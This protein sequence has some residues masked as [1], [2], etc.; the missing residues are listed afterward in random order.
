VAVAAVVTAGAASAQSHRS[1]NR[2]EIIE[3][4]EPILISRKVLRLEMQRNSDLRDW[5]RLYGAPDYA[6]VQEI[7]IDPPFAPYEVRLYYLKGN[8][9]LVFGRVHVA[10]SLYDYGV[11][12]YYGHITAADMDRLLTA[13]PVTYGEVGVTQTTAMATVPPSF[14]VE[15]L[16]VDGRPV[17]Q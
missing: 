14:T 15:T 16:A 7:E 13:Q 10:P 3:V 9:Y 5:I 4:G 2:P 12:K 8:A 6:E 1:V 11:H 17:A